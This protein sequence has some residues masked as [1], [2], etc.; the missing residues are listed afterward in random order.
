VITDLTGVDLGHGHTLLYL[1]PHAALIAHHQTFGEGM[2]EETHIGLIIFSEEMQVETESEPA[3]W[4]VESWEP[5][6]ILPSIG[7]QC[8][9]EGFVENGRWQPA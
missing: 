1:D 8:G 9:D 2:Q 4:I 6:T 5:L 7:C 3:Q